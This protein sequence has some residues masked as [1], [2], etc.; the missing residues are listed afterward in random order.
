M[1]TTTTTVTAA[2]LAA[3]ATARD[4]YAEI[5]L[6][7]VAFGDWSDAASGRAYAAAIR[8]ATAWEADDDRIAANAPRTGIAAALLDRAAGTVQG[9]GWTMPD[10]TEITGDWDLEYTAALRW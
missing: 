8:Q 10:T 2:L 1:T 6:A 7:D 9:E 4:E 3:F 5:V